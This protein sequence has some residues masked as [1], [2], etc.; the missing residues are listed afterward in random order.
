[1]MTPKTLFEKVWDRHLVVAQAENHPAIL[2]IDLHLL[3]EVTS[4]QAFSMIEARGLVTNRPDR[5][6]AT[7]DHATP[8]LPADESGRRPFV[9][10]AA[11]NQVEALRGN[12][13]HHGIRLFDWDD[14]RRGI[15]HVIGPELGLTMPGMT[16]VCGD[17]HTSTHGA[18][19]CL[20][21]G[22]GTS[23]VAHVLATQCLLQSKPRT[24]RVC[25]DGELAEGVSAKDLGL[26]VLA[27]LGAGGAI[28]HVIEYAGSAV[29]QLSMEGRM[30]L[31]NLSIECG[32]RAGMIS[33]DLTTIDWLRDRPEA[34][35]DFDERVEGW[36][37][38]ASDE[39]VTFDKEVFI[40]A[41]FV[42]PMATWGTTPDTAV[43]IDGRIPADVSEGQQSALAYMGLSAGAR[44]NEIDIDYVFIG[45]CTNGRLPDLREA[46]RILEGRHV[47][48]GVTLLVV[49]GSET[50]RK[51]AEAEGL[52]KVVVAAGGQWRI[53]GCSMCLGMNGDIV[54]PGKRV[55]ATSNRNFVGRQGPNA[56]TILA[57]PATAAASAVRG[58]LTDPRAMTN[59]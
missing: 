10:E 17:S 51:A 29:R 36:L 3:N 46:A 50:V 8:T 43:A 18:F 5:T 49:P 52:D 19:G 14:A 27:A 25:C 40:D 1:M 32:A 22:I 31:C 59:A 7:L 47:A 41:N 45:S 54:P 37:A 56:R 48:N 57:S 44:L 23:E 15:V 35:V 24:M 55:V 13:R 12:A 53:S 16:I 38:L 20:A 42:L 6:V 26:A 39:G 11:E 28:G 9:S 33:P 58:V 2:Y 34:P 30:T 4:P 21:F